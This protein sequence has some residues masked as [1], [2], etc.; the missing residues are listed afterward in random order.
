MS[1]TVMSEA[2]IS[3]MEQR[4]RHSQAVRN[5][6]DQTK[7]TATHYRIPRPTVSA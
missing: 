6:S 3:P 2:V 1:E 4:Y 5:A 7:V